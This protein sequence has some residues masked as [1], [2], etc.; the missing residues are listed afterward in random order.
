MRRH[1]LT[2]LGIALVAFQLA[3]SADAP[4]PTP[5]N[6][7]GGGPRPT[8]G[9]S[10]LQ[11]RLFTSNPNPTAGGCTMIQA[12]VTLNGVNVADGTGVAFS[13]DFGTFSQNGLAIVSVMMHGGEGSQ[14]HSS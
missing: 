14:E 7:G 4:A 12:I 3:C 1:A 2:L 6:Q 11:V 10:P 5:P 13:T 9:V 8:P